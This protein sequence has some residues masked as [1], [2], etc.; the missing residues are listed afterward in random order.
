[1]ATQ[2]ELKK[3]EEAKK[4]AEKAK[5][6]SEADAKVKAKAEADAKVKK[7]QSEPM[8]QATWAEIMNTQRGL[9]P[10]GK[11]RVK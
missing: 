5:A 9:R 6:K 2:E 4:L 10:D 8:K 1:M 3:I 7:V 11:P